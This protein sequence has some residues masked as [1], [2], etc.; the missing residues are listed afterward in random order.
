L[1]AGKDDYKNFTSVGS[2]EGWLMDADFERCAA[3][4]ELKRSILFEGAESD[5]GQRYRKS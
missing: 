5:E 3:D 2:P 1:V 4:S